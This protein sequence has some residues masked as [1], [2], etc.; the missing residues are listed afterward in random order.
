MKHLQFA[1]AALVAFAFNDPATAGCVATFTYTG[2]E[3]TCTV[4]VT[5]VYSFT[6]YG[7]QGG[8]F[9]NSRFGGLGAELGGSETLSAGTVLTLLVGG[10]GQFIGN[11]DGGSGGGGSFLVE[12]PAASYVILVIAG[13]GGGS[14]LDYNGRPGGANA[15]DGV[16]G[17]SGSTNLPGTAGSGGGGGSTSTP[18]YAEGGGGGGGYSGN[19][20]GVEGGASFLSGGAGGSGY[21]AGGFG[22]GGGSGGVSGGG[23]GYNGGGAGSQGGRGST[24]GAGGGGSFLDTMATQLVEIDGENSGNGEI[25]I[26]LLSPTATVPEPGM[27]AL[28]GLGMMAVAVGRRRR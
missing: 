19:G 10:A 9:S 20:G 4:D 28:F 12:G 3:Q 2:A 5:G 16:V 25:V 15:S 17:L 11:A 27:F 7:A 18:V 14:G 26:A 24:T 22:G 6:A 1:L 8:S 23:G 13:G 21:S